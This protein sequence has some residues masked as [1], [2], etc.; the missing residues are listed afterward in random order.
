[1]GNCQSDR[2][3]ENFG[4]VSGTTVSFDFDPTGD[5]VIVAI[6][7]AIA[8]VTGDNPTTLPPLAEVIDP[9]AL[10]TCLS[11]GNETVE[12]SFKYTNRWVS[13]DATGVGT[14]DLYEQS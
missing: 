9:D 5:N 7:E 14:I 2:I 4:H 6:V 10:E 12:V 8:A 11:S 13:L 3:T 1:M